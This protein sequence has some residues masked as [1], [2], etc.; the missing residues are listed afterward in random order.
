[1]DG[2]I[3]R[4]VTV[5]RTYRQKGFEL[6]QSKTLQMKNTFSNNNL[7]GDESRGC[8]T[9]ISHLTLIADKLEEQGYIYD[10]RTGSIIESADSK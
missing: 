3:P 4:K 9:L 2:I 7:A 1:M 6:V 10:P 8:N 5:S